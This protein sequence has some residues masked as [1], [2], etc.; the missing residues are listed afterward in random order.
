MKRSKIWRMGLILLVAAVSVS[1]VAQYSK[2]IY[3]LISPDEPEISL[4]DDV[5]SLNNVIFYEDFSDEDR[6]YDEWTIEDANNNNYTWD[7]Y[8]RGGFKGSA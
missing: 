8:Y 6:F 5:E 1:V 4:K 3:S 7:W 2:A